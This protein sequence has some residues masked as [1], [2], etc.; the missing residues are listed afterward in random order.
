MTEP[1]KTDVCVG[2]LAEVTSSAQLVRV[3]TSRGGQ[4]CTVLAVEDVFRVGETACD[5]SSQEAFDRC[6]V[7]WPGGS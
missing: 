3:P 2:P 4:H 7:V 5:P 6:W 1:V